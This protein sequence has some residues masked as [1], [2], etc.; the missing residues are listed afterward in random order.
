MIYLEKSSL[1]FDISINK[2]G[3]RKDFEVVDHLQIFHS[4]FPHALVGAE[5]AL[6]GL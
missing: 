6:S 5:G 2:G 3:F 1:M 4:E